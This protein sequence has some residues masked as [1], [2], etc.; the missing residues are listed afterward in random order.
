MLLMTETFHYPHKTDVYPYKTGVI[1]CGGKGSRMKEVTDPAGLP[2][3][4]LDI[5]DIDTPEDLKRIRELMPSI[6]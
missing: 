5:G 2:K 1:L 4:L 6:L 3:H